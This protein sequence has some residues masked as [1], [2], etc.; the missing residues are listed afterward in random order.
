[1]KFATI[2]D[3]R[4]NASKV[5]EEAEKEEV[6]VTKRGRPFALLIPISEED[7]DQIRKAI[8]AVKL[9]SALEDLWEEAKEKGKDKMT[10]EEID[11]EIQEHRREKRF[12]SST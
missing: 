11:A 2:R 9:R 8:K 1:M 10:M 3:F 7:I 5:M 4:I 12:K 6:V